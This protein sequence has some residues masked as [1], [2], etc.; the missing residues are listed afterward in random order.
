MTQ[1]L[2]ILGF[3]GSLRKGSFSSSLLRAADG[4]APQNV[5]FEIFPLNDIPI[6][7]TDLES[8]MPEPVRQFK[9]KIREA[10]AL[11]IVTPEYNHSIPGFL[12]NAIDWASRPHGDNSF[13]GKPV[14]IMSESTGMLGG[15]RAQYHLRQ[16][17]IFLNIHAVNRPEVMVGNVASKIDDQG[18]LT[19]EKTK[20]FISQLL[21]ALVD[22]TIQLNPKDAD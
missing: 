6:Y 10:D 1:R 13:D 16:T 5:N 2:S 7:N 4:L 18:N 20:D 9:Q 22:W 3:G 17:F 21:K 12:K 19:D 14:A 8:D 11:F 15:A